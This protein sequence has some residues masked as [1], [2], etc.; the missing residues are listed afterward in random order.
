MLGERFE[1][2]ILLLNEY[3]VNCR[4]ISSAHFIAP[5][6]PSVGHTP[7]P[8]PFR[9]LIERLRQL[10]WCRKICLV[11]NRNNRS[12]HCVNALWTADWSLTPFFI[13]PQASSIGYTPRS[14]SLRPSTKLSPSIVRCRKTCQTRD[15]KCRFSYCI[16]ALYAGGWTLSRFVL[17]PQATKTT[18][19]G[20]INH[21]LPY[22]M[23]SS[24]TRSIKSELICITV[25]CSWTEWYR[26]LLILV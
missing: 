13:S 16:D 1:A 7:M 14:I 24:L 12:Y 19:Y 21:K 8:L 9:P 20:S 3:T 2:Q 10:V 6:T 11:S 5:Q 4:L 17:A 26:S 15:C 22:Y 18:I 25:C 23:V